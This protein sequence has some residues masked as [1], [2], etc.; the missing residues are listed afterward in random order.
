MDGHIHIV[1]DLRELNAVSYKD[2]YTPPVL[3][4]FMEPFGGSQCYTVFDLFWEFD[5]RKLDLPSRSYT[6]FASPLGMLQLTSLPMEY[7]NSPAEFQNCMAFI[8]QHEISN[9]KSN[10]FIDNCPVRGPTTQ[11]LTHE[12]VPETLIQNPGIR[13]VIWEHAKD[14]HRVLHRVKDAGATFSAKK[15]Q[16]CREEVTILGQRCNPEGR[17]PTNNAVEKIL[18]WP[19]PTNVTQV[20]GF[21]GLCGT[22]RIW[23]QNYS[24]LVQPLTMLLKKEQGFVWEDAQ[25][26]AFELMKSKVTSAPALRAIDYRSHKP[27]Y[28]SV[29]T[30]YMAVGFIL[31]QNDEDDKRRVAH[32]GSL[33]LNE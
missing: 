18:D 12:E 21:L 25:Q 5:A 19:A 27:I 15:A 4:A 3:D 22:V 9:N 13:R 30:S 1:H 6:A 31:S 33:M 17:V 20:R 14:V 32:Y 26:S 28:L 2:A 16:I 29:D 8:L 7:T 10:I 24:L 11:Y 23:I